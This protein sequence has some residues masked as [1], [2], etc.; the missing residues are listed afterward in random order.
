MEFDDGEKVM[1]LTIGYPPQGA[2][3]YVLPV[4]AQSNNVRILVNGQRSFTWEGDDCR[5]RRTQSRERLD[6][7]GG[8]SPNISALRAKRQLSHPGSTPELFANELIGALPGAGGVGGR[9]GR[10]L[11]KHVDV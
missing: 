5:T 10:V 9:G 11:V 4:D 8:D 7:D 6:I 3:F 2:F 1:G